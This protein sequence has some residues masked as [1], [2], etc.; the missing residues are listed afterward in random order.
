[1][2]I[3]HPNEAAPSLPGVQPPVQT[4]DFYTVFNMFTSETVDRAER[5]ILAA[6][7]PHIMN[8]P[9]QERSDLAARISVVHIGIENHFL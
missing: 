7:K 9:F 6:R 5:G 3:E 2:Y 8:I 1:M 4:D